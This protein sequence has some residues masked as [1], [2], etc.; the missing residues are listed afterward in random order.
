MGGDRALLIT[1]HFDTTVEQRAVTIG[2]AQVFEKPPHDERLLDAVA[3]LKAAR[4]P[5]ATSCQRRSRA[6]Q[7]MTCGRHRKMAAVGNVSRGV[8]TVPVSA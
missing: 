4:E 1:G 5:F 7:S 2:C 8:I 3:R 6:H